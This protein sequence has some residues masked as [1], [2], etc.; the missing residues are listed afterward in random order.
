MYSSDSH[1][2]M[3]MY[4]YMYLNM[5]EQRTCTCIH[6]S[7]LP[8]IFR[9]GEERARYAPFAHVQNHPDFL[10]IRILTC[11]HYCNAVHVRAIVDWSLSLFVMDRSIP[12]ILER[13]GHACARLFPQPGYE[14]N[15]HVQWQIKLHCT[16]HLLPQCTTV[17]THVFSLT[18]IVWCI[19]RCTEAL[20]FNLFSKAKVSEFDFG[21]TRGICKQ[22]IFWLWKYRNNVYISNC[23]STLYIIM[24]ADLVTYNSQ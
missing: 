18:N 6:V 14:A 15:V 5:I 13:I 11:L 1:G 10:G 4:M 9:G 16:T 22:Q 17:H 2:Y 24:L 21:C 19:A 3:Y 7:L 12:Y 20:T 8:R 23:T